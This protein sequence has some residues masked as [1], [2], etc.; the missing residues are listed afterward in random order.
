MAG[1]GIKYRAKISAPV[2]NEIKRQNK[3]FLPFQQ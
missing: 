3:L 2:K 1:S